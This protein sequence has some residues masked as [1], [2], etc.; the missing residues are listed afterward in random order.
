MCLIIF[1]VFSA[2]CVNSYIDGST[3]HMLAYGAIA[4]VFGALFG[5]Q[6]FKNR[7]CIFAKCKK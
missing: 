6:I 5:Y 2:L 7:S 4:L 3:P 1:V